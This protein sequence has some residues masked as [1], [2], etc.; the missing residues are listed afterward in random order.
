MTVGVPADVAG[1][2]GRSAAAVCGAASSTRKG[3][4]SVRRSAQGKPKPGSPGSSPPKV[5]LTSTACI[6]MDSTTAA[7]SRLRSARVRPCSA[8]PW[9][10]AFG[11]GATSIACGGSGCGCGADSG[12]LPGSTGSKTT[13]ACLPA[14]RHPRSVPRPGALQTHPAHRLATVFRRPAR[15]ASG[16]CPH[17]LRQPEGSILR[18]PLAPMRHA[19]TRFVAC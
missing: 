14:Q 13:P 8:G 2:V 6:S 7:P 5:R 15:A 4:A 16:S 10:L 17:P 1:G 11:A 9:P 12:G 19:S 3:G 18:A